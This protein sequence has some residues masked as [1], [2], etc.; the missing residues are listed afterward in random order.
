M[1]EV[2]GAVVV[3]ESFATRAHAML[4]PV[5]INGIAAPAW[6]DCGTPRAVFSFTV[7]DGKI[8]AIDILADPD[9]LG[10]LDIAVLG[11]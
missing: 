11:D 4:R 9:L 2:R 1:K 7:T 3:A 8:T 10:Q 6:L 5:L